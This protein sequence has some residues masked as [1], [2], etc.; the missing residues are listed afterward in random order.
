MRSRL[1]AALHVRHFESQSFSRRV[2]ENSFASNAVF[3]FSTVFP[4][5]SDSYDVQYLAFA[6]HMQLKRFPRL[7]KTWRYNLL[8]LTTDL[9]PLIGEISIAFLVTPAQ[10]S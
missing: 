2:Q 1:I 10:Q 6:T 5:C 3:A 7:E 4:D 8:P 9:R